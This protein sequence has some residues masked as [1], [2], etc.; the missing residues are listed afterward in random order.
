MSMIAPLRGGSGG[1]KQ[2]WR[3]IEGFWLEIQGRAE[4][5]LLVSPE[6]MVSMPFPKRGL[7]GINIVSPAARTSCCPRL[8]LTLRFPPRFVRPA[9]FAP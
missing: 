6:P 1:G 7:N 3:I 4:K 8:G 9:I 5:N 2:E